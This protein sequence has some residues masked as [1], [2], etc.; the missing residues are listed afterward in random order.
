MFKLTLTSALSTARDFNRHGVA[1][2]ISYLPRIKNEQREIA[3]EVQEYTTVLEEISR[4]KLD[5]DLTV[6]L[7]QFGIFKDPRLT[8]DALEI[9]AEQAKA[10]NNFIWID[11]ERS[12]TVEDTIKIFEQLDDEFGNVGICLQAYLRRSRDDLDRILERQAPVRL[13]KGFYNDSDIR[14]WQKVTDNY[15][16]LMHELLSKSDRPCIATHDL[17][18]VKE[19]IQRIKVEEIKKAE[20]QFFN[21]VRDDFAALL[22]QDGYNTRIY[23][24]YGHVIGY[25]KDGLRTFD[26]RRHIQRLFGQNPIV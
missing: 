9:L 20:I 2:S 12:H 14:N 18:L 6:K 21:G 16:S 19:A 25:L 3:Q 24:P 8:L 26:I 15:R 10:H 5:S 4:N 17:D 1:A 22:S 13:V 7:Q 23:I 11:M